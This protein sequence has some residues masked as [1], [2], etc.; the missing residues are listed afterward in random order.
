M[1]NYYSNISTPIYTGLI[2]N[3]WVRDSGMTILSCTSLWLVWVGSLHVLAQL[4]VWHC[5]DTNDGN[6]KMKTI[7]VRYAWPIQL[8]MHHKHSLRFLTS[9]RVLLYNNTFFLIHYNTFVRT[10]IWEECWLLPC[11]YFLS[12]KPTLKLAVTHTAI[13]INIATTHTINTDPTPR[14]TKGNQDRVKYIEK[15]SPKEWNQ[16]NW[17]AIHMFAWHTPCQLKC[18]ATIVLHLKRSLQQSLSHYMTN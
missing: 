7:T 17:H 5:G 14:R 3:D 18:Y 9:V 2:F 4:T 10:W 1:N 11:L 6:V 12:K 13:T 15:Q 8:T 16:V